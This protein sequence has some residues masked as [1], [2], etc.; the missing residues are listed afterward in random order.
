MNAIHRVLLATAALLA[1]PTFATAQCGAGAGDC[2]EPHGGIGCVQTACCELV[3]AFD[4]ACCIF[5]WDAFCVEAAVELCV[6]IA[7]PNPGPCD[8]IRDAPGCEDEAC[9]DLVCDLDRFCCTT[10]WDAICAERAVLLCGRSACSI[11]IPAGARSEE[12]PCYRRLNDG[13]GM[14]VPAFAALACNETVAG[15]W[16]SNVPRD[17]DW[18]RIAESLS[19]GIVRVQSEFPAVVQWIGGACDG[20]LELLGEAYV[21]PCGEATL[22]VPAFAGPLHLTVSG[23]T[24]L[25]EF[26]RL[27]FCDEI[28]PDNPPDPKA[29][30]P[31]PPPFGR[32]Y[33]IE[34]SCGCPLSADLDGDCRVGPSDL[35]ILLAGWGLPGPTDLDGDGVTGPADLS[36]L[37]SQW[38]P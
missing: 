35:A 11:E 14:V 37:L 20:T 3:C 25:A 1:A 24:P 16:T 36:V 26:R 23:G 19:G 4:S 6:G 38:S 18:Y 32:R 12:E 10:G 7:C 31:P 5:G 15:K 34:T 21:D 8:E 29:P 17:L 28:N 13:C 27:F 22:A 2:Y 33:L 9:C 30:P